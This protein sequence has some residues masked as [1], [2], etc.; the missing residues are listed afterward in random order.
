VASHTSAAWL[1]GLL[2]SPPNTIHLTAPTR[3][4]FKPGFE[5]QVHYAAMSEGDCDEREGIPVT[6]LPRT[7]VDLAAIFPPRRLERAI[8]RAEELELFDLKAVDAL[9]ARVKRHP[10]I[11]SLR[12]ALAIYRD[13]DPAFIRSRLEKR[14]LK[15]VTA[16]GLP[17]PS[18]NFNVAGFELD[19]YWEQERFTVELDVYETHGSHAAFE[20]DRLRQEDLKLVGIEMTRVTGPRLDR[21]PGEV[22]RRVAVLLAQR[23]EQLGGG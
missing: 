12:G 7:L 9:L 3:R 22:M 2:R 18:M 8:E 23:R 17:V 10:G 21:E 16:A 15:L 13:D 6:A 11:R 4:R 14:F 19:A 5:V 1:L 20:R